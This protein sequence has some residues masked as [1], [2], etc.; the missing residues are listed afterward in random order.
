MAGAA[1]DTPSV[2]VVGSINVDDVAEVERI[3]RPGETV[4]ATASRRN[5]GGKGANQAV[6]ARIVADDVA[7]IG[8]VGTDA[9][10]DFLRAGLRDHG[11]DAAMLR[12]V[13][14]H[15]SGAAH[16][17]VADGENTIVVVGGANQA[18]D[19]LD[20]SEVARVGAAAVVVCQLEIPPSVV[21]DTATHTRGRFVLNAAPAG[22]VST[23]TLQR[24][25]PVVVNEHELGALTGHEVG[26]I[27]SV[28][29]AAASLLAHG[30]RSVVATLGAAGAV[31]VTGGGSGHTPAPTV[32]VVDSTGAG[33]LFVGVLAG[34]LATGA[35]MAAA[36][37]DAVA[38]AS[39]SVGAVGTIDSY[40]SR[41]EL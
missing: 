22:P 37:A 28:T 6:A 29:T 10:G 15:E 1:D 23:P 4:L 18:W 2:V 32:Q 11:V 35:S 36:V 30:A 19:T 14:G 21:D 13:D 3:P 16:I 20:D 34:R 38:A 8:R 39:V 7:F 27:A 24:C 33:D 9:H 40:P 5:V 26:D 31:W 25:D 41:E 17:T 12:A